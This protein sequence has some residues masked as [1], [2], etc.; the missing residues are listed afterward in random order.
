MEIYVMR[1]KEQSSEDTE[2]MDG[3]V[4][5]IRL[6]SHRCRTP[7]GLKVTDSAYRAWLLYGNYN[8]DPNS[9]IYR[10]KSGYIDTIIFKTRYYGGNL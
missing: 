3:K 7:R 8:S 2:L 5:T 1:L 6:L 10:V 4:C 9:I